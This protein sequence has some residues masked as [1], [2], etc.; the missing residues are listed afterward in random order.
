[1]DEAERCSVVGMMDKGRLLACD[2]PA[3]IKS[4][5]RGSV[6]ELVCADARATARELAA[7]P[8]IREVQ[9]FGDRLNIIVDDAARDWPAV[10]KKMENRG[11]TCASWREVSPS[12]E[13]VFI[14]LMEQGWHSNQV[15]L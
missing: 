5:M 7:D 6:I 4:R 11:V 12:L 15:T 1:M 8:L 14:S 2:A 13:N 9:T 10:R 3:A